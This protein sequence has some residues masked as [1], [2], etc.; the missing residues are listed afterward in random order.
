MP[1]KDNSFAIGSK[2]WVGI[3]EV[4]VGELSLIFAIW[5]HH[6]DFGIAV[7]VR[8]KNDLHTIG[9]KGRVRV[10]RWIVGQFCEVAPITAN[11]ADLGGNAEGSY[12]I[13]GEGDFAAVGRECWPVVIGLGLGQLL[14]DSHRLRP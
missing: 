7:S 6:D 11:N 1:N 8:V 9:R 10:N 13:G 5:V 12:S 3:D 4:V 2:H 14:F